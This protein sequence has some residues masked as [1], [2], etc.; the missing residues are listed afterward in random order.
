MEKRRDYALLAIFIIF[1]FFIS[2]GIVFAE[3]IDIVV[4]NSYFPGEDVEFK[5]V[6]YN[7]NN[8]KIDG[9]LGFKVQDYY[10]NIVKEGIVSSGEKINLKLPENAIRGLWKITVMFGDIKKEEWFDVGELEKAEIKLEG[11]NLIITN[12]GNVFYRKPISISIGDHSETALV[13]LAIGETKKI[14][15]TA[16]EGVYDIFVSDGTKENTLEFKGIPLTGKV[17]GLEKVNDS[18]WKGY[19]VVSLFLGVLGLVIII[20]AGLKVYNYYHR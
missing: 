14:R 7:D 17:I 13:R 18:F 9:S 16:P 11:S 5:A 3:K 10:T 12:I 6:L 15:L 1:I 8:E 2:S 19:P 4:G 20:V